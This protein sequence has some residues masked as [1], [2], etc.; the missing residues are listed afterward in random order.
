MADKGFIILDLMSKNM[1]LNLPTFLANKK[2]FAK[3]EATF[4]RKIAARRIH[5]EG[6][7]EWIRNYKILHTLTAS[8]RPFANNIVQVCSVLVSLQSP[9]ISRVLEMDYVLNIGFVIRYVFLVLFGK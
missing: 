3:E 9:I 4:S 6:P 8:L 2:Q 5:V 7:I 1:F